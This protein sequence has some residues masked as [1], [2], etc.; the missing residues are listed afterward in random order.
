MKDNG[1]FSI[2]RAAG[3]AQVATIAFAVWFAFNSLQ[4][5]CSASGQI[6]GTVILVHSLNCFFL[7]VAII[8]KR[9]WRLIYI[10]IVS[11]LLMGIL[12]PAFMH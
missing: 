8:A 5:S 12:L 6:G 10:P 4:M 11:F 2:I 3:A 7:L 1:S 9:R